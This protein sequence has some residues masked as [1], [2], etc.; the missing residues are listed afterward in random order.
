MSAPPSAQRLMRMRVRLRAHVRVHRHEY[1]GQTWHVLENPATGRTHRL[2]PAANE[3]LALLDGKLT[4]G[5]V[6]ELLVQRRGAEAPAAEDLL[7]L[8]GTL[9]SADLVTAEARADLEELAARGAHMQR[10]RL[11]QYFANPLALRIPLVDPDRYLERAAAWLGR[12]PASLVVAAW[13]A[14]VGAGVLIAASNWTTLTAGGLDQVFSM[15]NLVVLW[16]CYPVVKLLHEIG[17]GLVIRRYGGQVHEM[18]LMILVLVPVPYVDASAS[19][20]FPSKRARMLVG[21]AGI[22]TELFIA[23]IAMLAWAVL[24]PGTLRAVCFNIA[25]IAGVSTLVF[26]GNPLL[27]FDGYYVLADW[28]EIPNLGQ[29]ATAHLGWIVKRKAFGMKEVQS[30]AGSRGEARW[31]LAF[32]I[33]SGAYRIFIAFGIAALVAAHYFFVG[34]LLAA[35]AVFTMMV[36]PVVRG[37]QFVAAAPALEG[38]RNRATVVTA[39]AAVLVAALVFIVPAPQWTRTEGLVWAPEHA[40]VRAGTACFITRM[41]AAPG[42]DVAKGDPL[43]EC[44]DLELALNARVLEAQL[45]ELRARDMAYYVQSRLHLDVLRE[46]VAHIEQRLTEARRRLAALVIA[47]PAGGRFIMASPADAPG[48]HV[49]RGE[50]LGYVLEPGPATVRVVVRQSD[51]DLVRGSTL[52]VAVKPADRL[53]TSHGARIRRE[54][55]GASDRLPGVALAVAGGGSFEVDPRSL[56]EGS[57]EAPRSAE[58]VFQFDIEAAPEM[59]AG[60]LGLRVHVRFEHPDS[61]L[62]MQWYRSLRRML[63][64]Q[65][66]V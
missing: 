41:R 21:G 55:P 59:A 34:V 38:R 24:E 52:A 49:Q 6:H 9:Y 32:G 29:R 47:S 10:A 14:V 63:L 13:L 65:F 18:G 39:A 43:V 5:E 42:S 16:L 56:Q 37:I 44:E 3:A 2:D 1:R 26:N 45:T 61:P 50:L 51:A 48:R 28:L 17:H 35:W 23:G 66:N 15:G 20:A 31:L 36:M 53:D 11:R 27:R 12:L 58:P 40:Q 22:L 57:G 7:G 19:A 30:P 62:G 60:A 25:L 4:L 8:A 46:E 54:V 33:A 64:R